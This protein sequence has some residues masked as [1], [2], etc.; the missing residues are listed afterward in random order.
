MDLLNDKIKPIYFKYLVA[1]SGSTMVAS[2]FGMVDAI[3]VGR[4]HGPAG[5]I[6]RIRQKIFRGHI[7]QSLCSSPEEPCF[8]HL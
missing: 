1:A 5:S 6:F 4:Y 3:A 7:S 8:R 2:V